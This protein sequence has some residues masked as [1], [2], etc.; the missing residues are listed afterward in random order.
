MKKAGEVAARGEAQSQSVS[1]Y[2]QE[3]ARK[4][5]HVS[6]YGN[7]VIW[8]LFFDLISINL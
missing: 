5:G 6:H 4:R 1:R 7:H 3:P 8:I 2:A